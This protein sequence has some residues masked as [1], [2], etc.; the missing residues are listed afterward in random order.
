[1][2][3]IQEQQDKKKQN[4]SFINSP[5]KNKNIC[6]QE[7]ENKRV[8]ILRKKRD[9]RY[10]SNKSLVNPYANNFKIKE[11]SIE[12]LVNIDCSSFKNDIY[13]QL[14]D[15]QKYGFSNQ[16]IMEGQRYFTD[17]NSKTA[18]DGDFINYFLQFF[19]WIND[20][21]ERY[22][23]IKD[24]KSYYI[25]DQ[26]KAVRYKVK[27]F[28]ALNS[29]KDKLKNKLKKENMFNV[30]GFVFPAE[31]CSGEFS[32]SGNLDIYEP[33]VKVLAPKANCSA[34]L[35]HIHFTPEEY[36]DLKSGNSNENVKAKM[37]NYIEKLIYDPVKKAYDNINDLR[38]NNLH[39]SGDTMEDNIN[40]KFLK[41]YQ[42]MQGE[43]VDVVNDKIFKMDS[44]NNLLNVQDNFQNLFSE[45]VD[46]KI[47]VEDYENKPEIQ[48][49]LNKK[50]NSLCQRLQNKTLDEIVNEIYS[51]QGKVS[52]ELKTIGKFLF[53][54]DLLQQENKNEL[55]SQ[56][57]LYDC[58]KYSGSKH[59]TKKAKGLI[60]HFAMMKQNLFDHSPKTDDIHQTDLGDCYFLASLI[61]ILNNPSGPNYIMNMMRDM[62]DGT[63]VV[64]LY[65]VDEKNIDIQTETMKPHPV[66]VRVSKRGLIDNTKSALWVQ[67]LEQ[68]YALIRGNFLATKYYSKINLKIAPQNQYDINQYNFYKNDVIGCNRKINDIITGGAYFA[69][70]TLT[71]SEY[72]EEIRP[73]TNNDFSD[74]NNKLKNTN[75]NSIFTMVFSKDFSSDVYK[76]DNNSFIPNFYKNFNFY[77]NHEYSLVGYDDSVKYYI[78]I[79]PWKGNKIIYLPETDFKAHIFRSTHIRRDLD[80][81]KYSYLTTKNQNL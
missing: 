58:R 35:S 64:R 33:G 75:K 49:L 11:D 16:D 54:H 41:E 69:L 2:L 44:S 29:P 31:L 47:H 30:N 20:A 12:S 9:L 5:Q 24:N 67:I 48:N 4:N 62:G 59:F 81:K 70:I 13:K 36:E 42:F 66:H 65:K 60:N 43:I 78:V 76:K 46:T 52:E 34:E 61:S 72:I 79:N 56:N 18:D 15:I 17:L 6:L 57:S 53:L 14:Y 7:L 73:N 45:D 71:G 80:Y 26:L 68:A 27:M 40:K 63:V 8:E 22:A 28:Y 55:L 19:N 23:N 3:H 77:K 50:Q 10:H 74:L 25:A 21:I 1:M 51:N 39:F 38:K 37:N 32:P